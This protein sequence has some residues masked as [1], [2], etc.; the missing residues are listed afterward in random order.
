VPIR[1]HTPRIRN[2][3]LWI[4]S[5]NFVPARDVNQAGRSSTHA[6]EQQAARPIR[7]WLRAGEMVTR[8]RRKWDEMLDNRLTC[9]AASKPA[10]NGLSAPSTM[11]PSVRRLGRPMACPGSIASGDRADRR[12][13]I[14]HADGQIPHSSPAQA[15]GQGR[16]L[17]NAAL[18]L[19][20]L[21]AE[22]VGLVPFRRASGRTDVGAGRGVHH[23]RTRDRGRRGGCR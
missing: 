15:A 2:S 17:N 16:R 5:S 10:R 1:R 21:E 14:R 4:Q 13:R 19:I 12:R 8:E 22:S 3:K 7:A 23:R 20:T 9:G 6:N 18:G 11:P